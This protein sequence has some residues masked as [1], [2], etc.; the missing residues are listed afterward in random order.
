MEI[1]LILLDMAFV[2]Q[3]YQMA[4]LQLRV[5]KIHLVDSKRMY[6]CNDNR[7]SNLADS[8]TFY[9]ALFGRNFC[10]LGQDRERHPPQS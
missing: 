3:I 10:Y 6:W 1:F 4:S 2:L 9:N 8:K 7:K 5:Q